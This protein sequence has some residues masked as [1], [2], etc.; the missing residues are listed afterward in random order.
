[1]KQFWF[2]CS[3]HQTYWAHAFLIGCARHM[4]KALSQLG[5]S[6][7]LPT[8]LPTLVALLSALAHS[9]VLVRT[10]WHVRLPV[11]CRTCL[12]TNTLTQQAFEPLVDH[13]CWDKWFN[14]CWPSMIV[15]ACGVEKYLKTLLAWFLQET[16]KSHVEPNSFDLA[17]L[18]NKRQAR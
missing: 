7:R 18:F 4:V 15:E 3:M 14:I 13:D 11:L 10:R 1:M 16:T 12:S 17:N 6:V 2:V 8:L 5:S 9:T